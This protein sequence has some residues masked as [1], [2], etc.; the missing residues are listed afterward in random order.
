MHLSKVPQISL[1]VILFSKASHNNS[2]HNN[3]CTKG[4]FK[5]ESDFLSCHSVF[6]HYVSTKTEASM[7]FPL[8]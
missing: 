3:F 1:A 5:E 6:V 2:V 7:T 8:V 4:I